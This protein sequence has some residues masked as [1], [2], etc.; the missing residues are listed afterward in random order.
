MPATSTNSGW[1][2]RTLIRILVGGEKGREAALS[3]FP[4]A[5]WLQIFQPGGLTSQES[6]MTIGKHR[7]LHY[8]S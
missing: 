1:C 2:K 3:A 8:D 6:N 4:I 7:Y 5:L